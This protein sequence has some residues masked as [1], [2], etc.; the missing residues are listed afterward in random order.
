[1][2]SVPYD[3]PVAQ[4]DSAFLWET[5]ALRRVSRPADRAEISTSAAGVD[6]WVTLRQASELTGVPVATL[7]KWALHETVASYLGETPVGPLRMVSLQGIYRRAEDLGR[8]VQGS[9]PEPQRVIDLPPPPPQG[10]P[11]IPE[12]TMLVPLDAWT[13]VLTQLGNLHEAGQQ[14]AEARERAAKAETEAAF[15]RERLAE[16]RTQLNHTEAPPEPVPP[17]PPTAPQKRSSWSAI[18]AVWGAI[19]RPGR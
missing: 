18:R 17:S 15:L 3:W 2:A 9:A 16:L 8:E 1:M 12:G 19:K 7:R 13:R 11:A 10:E 4:R 14:V 5:E 6:D